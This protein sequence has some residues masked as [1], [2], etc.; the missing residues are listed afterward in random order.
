M[1]K[2]LAM[3][4]LQKNTSRGALLALTFAALWGGAAQAAE[5]AKPAPSTYQQERAACMNGESHQ[6]RQ[7]CL[8]E[9]GAAQQ[10]ARRGGLD[11]RGNYLKNALTRCEP[12]PPQDKKDCET[13]VHGMGNQSGSVESGGMVKETIT[14]EV[15][16]VKPAPMAPVAPNVAPAPRP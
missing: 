16:P 5:P 6:D 3:N 2:E 9:A 12:L 4:K 13:R 7:T 8:K 11:D 10:E 1:L 14:R 15:L